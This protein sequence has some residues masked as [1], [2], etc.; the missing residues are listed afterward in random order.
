MSNFNDGNLGCALVMGA[1]GSHNSDFIGGLTLRVAF[2]PEGFVFGSFSGAVSLVPPHPMA[3][4]I[5]HIEITQ[6]CIRPH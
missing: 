1:S 5:T 3:R 6:N 2:P 4:N